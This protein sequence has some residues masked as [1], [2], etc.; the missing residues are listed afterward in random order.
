MIDDFPF[1][2]AG[3]CYEPALHDEYFA[4]R[5]E[6]DYLE[7]PT[8][9]FLFRMARDARRGDPP[10]WRDRAVA[11]AA[12]FPVLA[13]GIRMGLGDAAP[14]RTAYLD[15]LAPFLDLVEPR[16][17][18]DHLDQG[19]IPDGDA[20]P[21]GIP[22]AFT[23]EQ[24]A[25]TRRNMRI[26]SERIRRPLIVENTWYD[27]VIPLPGAIGEPAFITEVLRDTEHGLLLDVTNLWIN[28]ANYGFD[29]SEWLDAAPLHRVVELHVAGDELRTTGPKAG[30]WCDS[31]SRPVPEEVWELVEHVV[32]RAPVRAITLERSNDIPPMAELLAEVER[33]RQILAGAPA[34]S[35]TR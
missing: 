19:N 7:L 11:L 17:F 16:W 20:L 1:L 4:H 12:A 25:L 8:D 18:S 10:V 15:L 23:A 3:L 14:Y 21:H 31:H 30:T 32:A 6:I 26:V 24:A 22:I 13:H 35:R 2:G 33:S 27:Y 9:M 5:D 28:A 29:V 34:L